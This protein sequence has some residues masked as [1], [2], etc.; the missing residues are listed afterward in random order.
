MEKRRRPDPAGAQRRPGVSVPTLPR[1]RRV[2]RSG[3]T[4]P[5]H[6][7]A[8]SLLGALVL[9]LGACASPEPRVADGPRSHA[10]PLP[11]AFESDDLSIRPIAVVGP[12]G[13]GSL[14]KHPGWREYRLEVINRSDRPLV[15]EDVKLLN[16]EGRYLASAASYAE[17]REPPNASE[18]VAAQVARRSAGIAAGQFIPYGGTV[19]GL[20]STAITASASESEAEAKRRFM[21]RRLKNVELAP[22]GRMSGSAFLPHIADA[23]ALSIVYTIAERRERAELPLRGGR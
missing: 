23:H 15:V 5:V 21:F 18:E 19:V 1:G 8:I 12:E 6:L 13:Q 4:T 2:A 16:S 10:H 11:A 20:I 9:Y 7:L 22:G 3:G 17:L 14:V